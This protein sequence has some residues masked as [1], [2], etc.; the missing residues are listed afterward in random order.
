L[1]PNLWQNARRNGLVMFWPDPPAHLSRGTR[2]A[3]GEPGQPLVVHGKVYAPD[4]AKPAP[5]VTVY[6][7]NT[8]AAGYYGAN[9]TEYPPRLHGWML[10][11][12]AGEF[13]LHTIRPGSYPNTRIPA[14]V[15]FSFWG[16]GYPLQWVDELRFAGDPF[17]TDAMRAEAAPLGAFSPIQ[18]VT[19]DGDGVWQCSFQI[20]AGRECNFR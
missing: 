6:A 2:I 8:D 13:E 15:H 9:H 17:V 18:P 10:T 16:G 7:Y 14:H 1:P 4:G 19:R 3:D 5:G 20:R 12:N 11:D